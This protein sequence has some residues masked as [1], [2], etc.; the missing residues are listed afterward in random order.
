MA[1][2]LLQQCKAV[3]AKN[4]RGNWTVPAGD[5]YP[6]QWLWDSCFI[7]IGLRN[8]DVARAQTELRSLLR[9]QWS[10]GMLPDMIFTKH[11]DFSVDEILWDSYL[12]P[13]APREVATSGITQPPMLAEAVWR[14]GENLDDAQRQTWFK[15]MLP[16]IIKFHQWL[17]NERDFDAEGLVTLIHPYESGLDNS[18]PW[19]D[20]LKAR[21]IP[22]WVRFGRW[23]GV[24]IIVNLI[25]RDTRHTRDK[26]RMS[27]T[28]ALSFFVAMRRLR[29]QA[30]DSRKVLRKPYLAIQDLVFNCILI[31]ANSRMEEI[32]KATGQD[33]PKALVSQMKQSEQALE[34]LWDA[35]TG[36]YFCHS[37]SR[38]QLIK[39]PSIA[40]LMPLYAGC[41][42]KE[43]AKHLVNLLK[44]KK[45]F[46]TNWPIPSTPLDS[47]FF[48][49]DKYWQGP[50]WI[51]MNWLIID[52]LERYGY[53]DEAEELRQKTVKLVSENGVHEYYNPLTGDG[54]GAKDFGWTAALTVDL[55][56]S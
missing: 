27:A 30:Y 49:P 13:Y 25:R 54:E 6:H 22:L 50:T 32:A 28:E 46:A 42:S 17:Y 43:R 10:N 2:E 41:I 36:Q 14:V 26:Q 44:D 24:D 21:R 4:D 53:K 7:A 12:S 38:H 23:F 37:F 16:P 35:T 55:L 18:P 31:R 29:R 45:Q 52:G 51:N 47:R 8:Y 5:L 40:T 15:E 34:K 3:L 56:K 11:E 33:L 1:D 39:E 20:E 9:G 48:N 19:I